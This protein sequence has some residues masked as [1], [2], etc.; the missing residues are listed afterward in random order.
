VRFL[1]FDVITRAN[2]F[3]V[4]LTLR[5]V[6]SSLCGPGMSAWHIYSMA[7]FCRSDYYM[8]SNALSSIIN[9]IIS[10]LLGIYLDTFVA[11]EK[12][13]LGILIMRGLAL[14]LVLV[15]LKLFWHVPEPEYNTGIENTN[16]ITFKDI[17]L[18]PVRC[19]AFVGI[20]MIYVLYVFGSGMAPYYGVYLRDGAE[21][22]YTYQSLVG[23]AG[24]PCSILTLPFWNKMVHK[25]GWLKPMSVS[26][27]LYAVCH[28]INALVTVDTKW[29]FFV[30]N[31]FCQFVCGGMQF[32]MSNLPFLRVPKDLQTGCLA[33]YN[34]MG[35]ITGIGVAFVAQAFQ[36]ATDG[37]ILH[38]FGLSIENRAYMC[39]FP[40]VIILIDAG[41]IGWLAFVEKRRN[42]G[43]DVGVPSAEDAASVSDNA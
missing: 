12:A 6:A 5:T 4:V 42:G 20:V 37:K 8:V 16:R 27:A 34:A 19:R 23:I 39:F 31:I 25:Y 36:K 40:F 2:V 35:S 33:F 7:E 43:R 10:L 22:S 32:G 13:L 15:E 17:L 21:L 14:L 3:V 29:M 24:V 11:N 30:S 1:P 26:L 18:A 9:P 28:A 38:L 41:I